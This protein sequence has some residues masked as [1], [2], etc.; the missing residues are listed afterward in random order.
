[1]QIPTHSRIVVQKF[2]ELGGQGLV[3]GEDEGRLSHVLDD[4]C[5]GERLAGTGYAKERLELVPLLETFGNL[6]G[7][8]CSGERTFA[9]GFAYGSGVI[10]LRALAM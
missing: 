2:I 6:P 4:V 10:V 1:M 5:H 9:I 8:L 7:R 3:V